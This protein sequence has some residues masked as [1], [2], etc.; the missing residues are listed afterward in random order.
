MSW[1]LWAGLIG[2]T[3]SPEGCWNHEFVNKKMILVLEWIAY[4]MLM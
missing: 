3:H 1:G 4:D 2:V